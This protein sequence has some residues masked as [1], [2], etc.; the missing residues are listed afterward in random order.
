MPCKGTQHRGLVGKLVNDVI[1]SGVQTL[2][3]KSDQETSIM[4]V[5]NALMRGLRG[6]EGF[7]VM[8][9]ESTQWSKGVY[10]RCRALRG[11]LMHTLSGFIELGSAISAWA[12]EY[13][14]QVV[15]GFQRC[16]SDGA[17]A[18][19]RRKQKNY[20]RPLVPSSELVIFMPIEKPMEK[21]EVRYRV[22]IVLGLVYRF[23]DVVIGTPE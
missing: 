6:I 18:Y 2:L 13:S 20:R 1:M 22:G 12:E 14:G 8:P 4:D 17:A 11:L 19:R 3:I 23:H 7:K 5:K 9:E 10:G 16:V 21:G 15:S